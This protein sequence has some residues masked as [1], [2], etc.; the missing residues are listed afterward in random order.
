MENNIVFLGKYYIGDIYYERLLRYLP[1]GKNY[2]ILL[3]ILH[4]LNYIF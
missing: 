2:I 4:I 3:V 1:V